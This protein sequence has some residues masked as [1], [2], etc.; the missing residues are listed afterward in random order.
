M[1]RS[2]LL[3]VFTAQGGLSA[4]PERTYANLNCPYFKVDVKF[5]AFGRPGKDR[6][7]RG[8]LVED[9][10]DVIVS[11]SRPYLEFGGPFD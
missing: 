11:I 7:G 3:S 8:I 2:D 9:H 10:R 4:P 6:D 1:K 5:R